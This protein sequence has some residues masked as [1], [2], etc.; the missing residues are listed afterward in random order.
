M[1]RKRMYVVLG[2]LVGAVAVVLLVLAI[3]PVASATTT[4]H[5]SVPC[6]SNQPGCG[7]FNFSSSWNSAVRISWTSPPET[8]SITML[9]TTPNFSVLNVTG[10]DGNLSFTSTGGTTSCG[11]LYFGTSPDPVTV[12]VTIVRPLL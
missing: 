10:N 12:E 11:I 8:L 5:T 9:C 2:A 7:A 6:S 3:V 4:Y 1:T